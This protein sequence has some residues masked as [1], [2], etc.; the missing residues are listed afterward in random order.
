MTTESQKKM[1]ESAINE[2]LKA[3]S[4]FHER[5]SQEEYIA[6]IEQ[7]NWEDGAFL[8]ASS[9]FILSQKCAQCERTLAMA[10]LCSSIEAMTPRSRQIDFYTWLLNNK[11]QT[12][13]LK[14]EKEIMRNLESAQREWFQ[15]SDR[16]GASHNFRQFLLDYCPADLRTPPIKDSKGKPMSFEEALK[17][18]YSD[19]RSLFLH[20]GLSTASFDVPNP[21]ILFEVAHM[22]IVKGVLFFIDL[23]RIVP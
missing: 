11:I 8:R 14:N 9:L 18:I 22:K 21:T 19:F 16:E 10:L 1:S 6:K 17:C 2:Y 3:Y 4:V 20:E 23:I 5:L 13:T 15:Q 7:T 12:L